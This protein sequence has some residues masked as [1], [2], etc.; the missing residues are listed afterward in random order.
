[1]LVANTN[2]NHPFSFSQSVALGKCFP[3]VIPC[4]LHSHLSPGPGLPSLCGDPYPPPAPNHISSLPT[5]CSVASPLPLVVQF[6]SQSSDGFLEYSEWFDIYLTVYEG[7]GKCRILLLL[8]HLS[9]SLFFF[10]YKNH[11]S[12]HLLWRYTSKNYKITY[13][14]SSLPQQ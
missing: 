1:M 5:F 3:C 11:T 13:E 2:E 9:S 14:Q 7:G 4:A 6:F 12:L 10:N 8:C